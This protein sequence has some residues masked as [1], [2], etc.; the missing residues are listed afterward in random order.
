MFLGREAGKG[1]TMLVSV[2]IYS[3]H[4]DLKCIALRRDGKRY[5]A[6]DEVTK[7]IVAKGRYLAELKQ[8]LKRIGYRV[9]ANERG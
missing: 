5:Y 9:K 3:L 6:T 2:R 1:V 4:G 7:R 8:R